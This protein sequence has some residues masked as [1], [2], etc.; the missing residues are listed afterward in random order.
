MDADLE[1]V[2]AQIQHAQAELDA[3]RAERQR[4]LEQSFAINDRIRA[5]RAELNQLAERERALDLQ[6]ARAEAR[7]M[8]LA[9]RW[10]QLAPDELL[11]DADDAPC[12]TSRLSPA[13]NW[14]ACAAPSP[15]WAK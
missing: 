5:L 6:H 11:P 4:L 13:R 1:R 10:R 14:N 8:E 3:R 9:E 2:R 7:L 12:P 15:R